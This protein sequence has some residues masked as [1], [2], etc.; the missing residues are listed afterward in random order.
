[1]PDTVDT[2][3]AAGEGLAFHRLTWADLDALARGDAS[4]EIIR[5]LRG[6]ERS[7]R[8]LLLRALLDA[9]TKSP[10]LSGPLPS[11]EDAWDLL[12]RVELRAPTA[13][14]EILAHP[15]TGS[16]AGYTIRLLRN[17]IAGTWP[18]SFQVGHLHA[19]A[20]AAAVRAGIPFR[21]TIPLWRGVATLP[22]LGAIRLPVAEAWSVAEIHGDGEHVEAS[23]TTGRVRLPITPGATAP[24]WLPL[25]Q[26]STAAG[27]DTLSVRLDD[28]DPFR[29]LYE[30]VAPE[31]ITTVEVQA[32]QR[33]LNQA[34]C[35]ITDHL[36]HIA[37]AM[38]M[39]LDSIVPR[40]VVLFRNASASTGEAFGSAIIARQPDAASLAATLVHEF[41]HIVLGGVLHL[42]RLHD[43]DPRMRFYA[44][45]RDDPRP[46]DRVLQGI[47]AHFGVADFWRAL[48]RADD[49]PDQRRAA[50]E[51]AFWRGQTWRALSAIRGD[52]TL[53]EA[54]NRFVDGIAARL[55]PW[56]HEP[57]PPHATD[58]A[59]ALA[60]DHYAGWRLRHLRPRPELVD[61]VVEAWCSGRARPPVID[62]MPDPL[63]TP[64]PDGDWSH[65]R[66]DLV[67]CQLATERT[68]DPLD[69]VPEATTADR[70]YAAGQ[71]TSAAAGYRAELSGDPDRPASLVGLG[72]TLAARGVDPAAR[73]LL[74]HPELVRAVHRKLRDRTQPAP[75]PEQLASWIGVMVH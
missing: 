67:R 37:A 55:E 15:Y 8:L 22:S 16:W 17:E 2:E 6:A 43:D 26:I 65:A 14:D 18:L 20:A 39:G 7:R 12:A 4:S 44:P 30:P 40:P 45:W 60:A 27:G 73:A 9:V 56:Q 66:A 29:S 3:A 53:T 33:L 68:T 34:W 70:A 13:F 32:W 21:A 57:V 50:T 36:P 28:L 10:T 1:M 42:V 49:R 35:L 48:S 11:P 58:A 52:T 41:N 74:G 62:A 5:R 64:V 69:A 47:Y 31:R 63:P 25:R 54:G 19:I 46:L 71:H 59:D 51:F 23:A 38:A 61:T 24:G 75:S 72:L